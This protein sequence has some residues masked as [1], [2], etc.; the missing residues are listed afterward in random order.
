MEPLHI[1]AGSSAYVG[2]CPVRYTH[3]T[4]IEAGLRDARSTDPVLSGDSEQT[5]DT[6]TLS[7]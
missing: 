2:A 3:G 1:E 6:E 7:C 5:S 4:T